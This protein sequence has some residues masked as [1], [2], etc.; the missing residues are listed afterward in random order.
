MIN[1]E[2]IQV[3]IVDDEPIAR[4]IMEVYVSKVPELILAGK[5]KNA[6]E[7]FQFIGNN[8]VD[9]LLLDINI[10]EISG[11][12]FLKTLKDPPAVIFT[13]AY[14]EY[15]L[16]SYDLDAVDYLLKPVSFDRFLK[17]IQKA[18]SLLQTGIVSTTSPD[19]DKLMFVK[20][21]GR[22]VKIDLT[23]LWFVEGLKDYVRL[24]T[25]TGKIIV[26][27]TM[28]SFEDNLSQYPNF[29]RVHKSYIVNMEHIDE[30]DGNTILIKKQPVAIGNTYKDEVYKILNGYKF[31]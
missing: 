18:K 30:V 2:A 15:A 28:K 22:L 31:L 10:P 21:E 11:I 23:K 12:N 9:L 25:D 29:T 6:I 24:W 5:C 27:S 19:T 4:D 13:T 17:G 14:S 16:E 26:H 20:S 8:K 1:K 7:A 3:L